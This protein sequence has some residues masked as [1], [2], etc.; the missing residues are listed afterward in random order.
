MVGKEKEFDMIQ[1]KRENIYKL[2]SLFGD[3]LEH[4]WMEV[5][6]IGTWYFLNV[7][8]ETKQDRRKYKY[9]TDKF[10]DFFKKGVNYGL[11]EKV[12]TKANQ[13]ERRKTAYQ[14]TERDYH[15]KI[16]PKADAILRDELAQR[17]GDSFYAHMYDR[18]VD[19][20]FGIDKFSPLQAT[21][22]NIKEKH[23]Y[24]AKDLRKE[25]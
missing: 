19:G 5:V 14:I 17:S 20:E 13:Q 15:Y 11:I 12:D 9:H 24:N 4:P 2:I 6:N 21:N 23:I 1:W 22:L 18:T 25:S 10:E 7:K 16:T 3:G 8:I